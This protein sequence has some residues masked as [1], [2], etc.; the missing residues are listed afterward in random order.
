MLANIRRHSL[1]VARL[2]VQLL[3]GLRAMQPGRPQASQELVLAGA[4][5]HDIAKTPCLGSR[6]DHAHEGAL[7]CQR[8]GYPQVAEIVAQHVRL[9][10]FAEARYAAGLFGA[11]E[12]VH[13][14]DKR[15]RH[16]CVVSL[17][18]RLEYILERYG[19]NNPERCR[20]IELHFRQC[21]RLEQLLF[22]HLPFTPAELGIH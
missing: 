14:A 16:H 22:D 6:C 18:E 8:E 2:A 17:D 19:R 1:V 21:H 20:A 11:P 15:V 9:S 3:E 4:L 13:Y 12:L 7:I 5:L 10:P